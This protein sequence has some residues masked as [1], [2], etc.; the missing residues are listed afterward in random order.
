MAVVFL[1]GPGMWAAEKTSPP[2]R[3]PI[4]VRRRLAQILRE[5]GHSVVLME[6][7][8][9][10]PGEGM[11]E[12]FVRI[13]EDG[14][15][16]VLLYWPP[17]A[18]MQTTYDELLLLSER[19]ALLG[20]LRIRIWALHHATVARIT[21]DEFQILESGQRS[22]YLTDVARLGLRPLEWETVE[23]LEEQVRLLAAE[24]DL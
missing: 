1:L 16:E 22:R 24:L 3:A 13:L 23:D 12:K 21:S 4:E 15:T 10:L 18:K 6:E 14:V 20:E 9:D 2:E 8:P 11:V 19:P 5:V 17:K 7:V